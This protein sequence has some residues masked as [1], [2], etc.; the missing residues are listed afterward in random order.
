[1]A[2]GV[3]GTLNVRGVDVDSPY[4]TQIREAAA[5]AS[6]NYIQHADLSQYRVTVQK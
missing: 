4:T 1:L 2:S 5:R 3:V 6:G